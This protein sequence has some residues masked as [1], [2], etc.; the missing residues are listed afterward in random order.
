MS[1]SGT[2]KLVENIVYFARALRRAGVPVG[3][4]AVVDAV[5]AVE[6]AGIGTRD[7]LYWGLHSIFVSKREHRAVFDEAFLL[8][9]RRQNILGAA[10]APDDVDEAEERRP[11]ARRAADALY[12]DSLPRDRVREPE[13][14]V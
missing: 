12:A 2:G 11:A 5:R 13:S 8:F 9:W 7:D 4:A 3:P 6:I 1:P 14:E 10:L